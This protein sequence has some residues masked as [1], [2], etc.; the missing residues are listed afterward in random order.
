MR[1][2]ELP[3][4]YR[5]SM[6]DA[7]W[8]INN[9]RTVGKFSVPVDVMHKLC[10]E[11]YPGNENLKEVLLK[12]AAINAFSSTHVY[13]LYSMAEHIVGMQIDGRLRRGDIS[14]VDSIAKIIISGKSYNFYSFATKYC[15]YHNPESYPIYDNYVARVLCS[16]PDD[17]R[18]IK[19][20]E[21]RDYAKFVDTLKDF[22]QHYELNMSFVELD[23]YLWRLGRW[24]LNPYEPTL[25]YY[26]R[27]NDNPFP[28][29]DVRNKFWY[30]EKMFLD[31]NDKEIL[32]RDYKKD[33]DEWIVWLK[34]NMPNQSVR[35]LKENTTE[36]L[37]MALYIAHIW[38][39]GCPYDD[40]S[41]IID[42]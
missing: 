34:E 41:W 9:W 20:K 13:D 14:L 36:Q 11:T 6:K 12:C 3:K 15:H 33:V 8:F 38:G 39:K 30:G 19:E 31:L 21:L 16:F 1:K 7:E 35:F 37:C 42:Y 22:R 29:D 27:E 10:Q 28:P 24:Y 26:H 25:K 4:G 2:K 17:F 23:K 32:L 5:P 40:H 18:V